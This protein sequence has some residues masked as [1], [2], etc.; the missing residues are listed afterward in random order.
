MTVLS[1]AAKNLLVQDKELTPLIGRSQSW[2]YWIF[3]DEPT[4]AK[5][6]KTSKVLIVVSEGDAWAP[7]NGHN[8]LWFPTL[9]VDIW[10]DPTRNANGSVRT[11]DAKDKIERIARIVDRHFHRVDS[12]DL[13]GMP[14]VWGTSE[15][16]SAKTGVIVTGS[17]RGSGNVIYSPIRDAEGAW[18]G[19]LTYNIIRP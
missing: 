18:M 16:I 5:F 19:R 7:S 15:E 10:A 3:E 17:L 14:I 4:G 8:T 6:E 2:G 1:L 12:A 9:Y 11:P 13:N